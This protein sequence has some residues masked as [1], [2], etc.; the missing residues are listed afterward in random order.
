MVHSKRT[1][2]NRDGK[3]RVTLPLPG[4]ING[5]ESGVADSAKLGN[6]PRKVRARAVGRRDEL[7]SHF[8][9]RFLCRFISLE[10]QSPVSWPL[11]EDAEILLHP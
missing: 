5:Y 10:R 4:K 2:I 1:G 7:P 11:G 9:Q 3:P 8:M 6:H